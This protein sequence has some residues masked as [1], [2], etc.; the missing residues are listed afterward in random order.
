MNSI[1][2]F[3]ILKIN[4]ILLF[5]IN[6][7]KLRKYIFFNNISFSNNDSIS[8]NKT[9]LIIHTISFQISIFIL[10]FKIKFLYF[11]VFIINI[12]NIILIFFTKSKYHL[13]WLSKCL[14]L[15]FNIGALIILLILSILLLYKKNNQNIINLI[16]LILAIPS[17]LLLYS[18]IKDFNNLLYPSY[19][20]NSTPVIQMSCPFSFLNKF[21]N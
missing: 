3:N 4:H 15:I 21:I 13:K 2:I 16:L 1:N 10:F 9:N 19:N 6:L 12:I 20:T 14:S 11:L 17:L 8:L 18:D 5:I 7:L